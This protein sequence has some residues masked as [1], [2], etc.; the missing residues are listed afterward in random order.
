MILDDSAVC[1]V[2]QSTSNIPGRKRIPVN[3]SSLLH[4][5]HIFMTV[6]FDLSSMLSRAGSYPRN[7]FGSIASR[8]AR[9]GFAPYSFINS[10][11]KSCRVWLPPPTN[12]LAKWEARL[13]ETH[14]NMTDSLASREQYSPT[15]RFSANCNFSE[16]TLLACVSIIRCAYYTFINRDPITSPPITFS[17]S[18]LDQ[19][20]NPFCNFS[21]HIFPYQHAIWRVSFRVYNIQGFVGIQ[22][23]SKINERT[24]S[25]WWRY[26]A[27]CRPSDFL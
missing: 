10:R 22:L 27:W 15:G 11:I 17:K 20:F 7:A 6:V 1:F 9:G 23:D 21:M 4:C 24:S 25:W 18:H 2:T 19:I 14:K 8:M 26:S 12:G 3:T 13:L 5:S 16:T